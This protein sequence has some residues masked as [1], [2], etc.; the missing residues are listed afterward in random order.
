MSVNI[1]DYVSN[2]HVESIGEILKNQS[3]IIQALSIDNSKLEQEL[4]R[5]DNIINELKE[6]LNEPQITYNLDATE[7]GVEK[8][9]CVSVKDTLNKIK[10]LESK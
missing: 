9:E 2:D 3:A 1:R 10:E 4:Q 6:W 7:F 8:I 5:K